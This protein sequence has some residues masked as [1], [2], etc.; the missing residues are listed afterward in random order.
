MHKTMVAYIYVY[1]Y[2]CIYI[3]FLIIFN[4]FYFDLINFFF[5]LAADRMLL[6]FFVKEFN[7]DIKAKSTIKP[8]LCCSGS[9]RLLIYKVSDKYYCML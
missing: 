3:L 2:V 4:K 8:I 6:T 7:I 5:F 9:I 1:I